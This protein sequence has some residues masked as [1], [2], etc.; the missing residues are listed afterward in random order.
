MC[1]QRGDRAQAWLMAD[2]VIVDI[3]DDQFDDMPDSVIL[4][5][6]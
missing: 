1:G 3:A 4:A 6:R 5:S 2:G